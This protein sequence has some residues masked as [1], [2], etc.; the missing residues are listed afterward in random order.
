MGRVTDVFSDSQFFTENKTL[1]WNLQPKNEVAAT[2]DIDMQTKIHNH[3][4]TVVFGNFQT[5]TCYSVGKV[6]R[7]LMTHSPAATTIAQKNFQR[8]RSPSNLQAFGK[9]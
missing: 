2:N 8:S 1:L 3:L 5:L 7:L 4:K 9:G 6:C